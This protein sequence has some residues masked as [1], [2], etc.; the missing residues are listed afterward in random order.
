MAD[1]EQIPRATM[2]H[3]VKS[4]CTLKVSGQFTDSL[5]EVAKSIFQLIVDFI[6]KVTDKANDICEE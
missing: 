3:F 5:L 1:G 2:N 4:H 6:R